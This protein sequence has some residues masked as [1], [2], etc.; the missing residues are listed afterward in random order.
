MILFGASELVKSC[1]GIYNDASRFV[2]MIQHIGFVI[3]EVCE[4]FQQQKQVSKWKQ[5][6]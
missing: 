4:E 1:Y 5:W 2:E 3:A 6:Q